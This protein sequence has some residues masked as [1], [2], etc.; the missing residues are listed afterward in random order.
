MWVPERSQAS[1]DKVWVEER[2]PERFHSSVFILQDKNVLNVEI[3]Q[4]V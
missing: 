4:K 1:K 2:F 3:L